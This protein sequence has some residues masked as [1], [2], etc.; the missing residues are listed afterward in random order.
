VLTTPRIEL[1]GAPVDSLTM[2]EA[3]GRVEQLIS[4]GKPNRI[5]VVNANKL[6]Q[7]SRDPV[8]AGIVRESDMVIPEWSVVW[9]AKVLG[10]PLRGHVGGITLTQELLPVA[11]RRG[12]PVFF[13]GARPDVLETLV[14][15]VQ[16]RYPALRVAGAHH[17]FFDL[18]DRTVVEIVRDA[19]PAILFI[20]MGS[21][22]QER[23]LA[24]FHQEMAVPVSIGVGGT[25]DVLAGLKRDA[26]AWARGRGLEW[27]VRLAQDPANL[28]R[29]YL[30]TNTWFVWQ[31]AR[32]RLRSDRSL[33]VSPRR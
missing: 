22:R 12:Y 13:L 16:R 7:A 28:W 9:A 10:A 14:A 33:S 29:R 24:R 23:W 5:T 21:P 6:W 27:L 3:I 32:A 18:E 30:V 15:T 19:R 17:G 31:V 8:L 26:P 2:S 25:F 20:G 1:L 4:S 11:A